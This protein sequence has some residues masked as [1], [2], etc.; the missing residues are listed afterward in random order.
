MKVVN[1]TSKD[2]RSEVSGE[3]ERST[4][5]RSEA[6]RSGG[7]PDTSLAPTETTETEVKTRPKRR[8]FTTNYKLR[9]LKE[10]DACSNHGEIGALL[11][12]EGLYSSHIS[13]W[14]KARDEGARKGL[15]KKRGPAPA[16]KNP[17]FDELK[18]LQRENAKLHKRLAKA[19][20]IIEFQKKIAEIL[21]GPSS[22][23][24][25]SGKSNGRK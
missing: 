3:T 13:T 4:A 25:S 14:R 21:D 18:K 23:K 8:Y 6:G 5:E 16:P 2:G 1:M 11:R 17:F 15:G 22:M 10:V 7:S 12:R 24:G 9:I 20:A 19:E